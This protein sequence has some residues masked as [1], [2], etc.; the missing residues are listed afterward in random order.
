MVGCTVGFC[1]GSEVIG[2]L[3]GSLVDPFL[4]SLL[5][6]SDHHN[7]PVRLDEGGHNFPVRLDEGGSPDVGSAVGKL[8][9]PLGADECSA[10]GST[11]GKAMGLI[12]EITSTLGCASGSPVGKA[13]IGCPVGCSGSFDVGIAEG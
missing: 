8:L 1:D 4:D 10:T 12:L 6:N 3:E 9:K 2:S 7:F 11:E 5:G 13:A